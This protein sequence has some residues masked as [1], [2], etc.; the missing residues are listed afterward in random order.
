MN[1][2][3]MLTNITL[4]NGQKRHT[5]NVIKFNQNTN[6]CGIVCVFFSGFPID[7]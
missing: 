7:F 2:G 5:P 6:V 1:T 3:T 4:K